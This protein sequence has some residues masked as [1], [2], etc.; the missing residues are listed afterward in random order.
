MDVC[1][2]TGVKNQRDVKKRL[3]QHD[4]HSMEVEDSRGHQVQTY[5]VNEAGLYDVILDSRKPFARSPM[6]SVLQAKH[7]RY[8]VNQFRG[9]YPHN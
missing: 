7:C 3:D 4:L 8:W 6:V 1:K 2:A 9:L 5:V